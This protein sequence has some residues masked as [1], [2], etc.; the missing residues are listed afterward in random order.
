MRLLRAVGNSVLWLAQ[1]NPA[2][3]DNLRREAEKSKVAPERVIFAPRLPEMADHLARLRLADLFLDTLPYNGHVTASDALWAGLP[4]LT[5]L[6]ATF[7]GRVAASQLN[8]VGLPE[9]VTDS[10]ASYERLA[11]KLASDEPML[12]ALK[13]RLAAA[14]QSAPLFDAKRF[15]RHVEAAYESMSKGDRRG[16]RPRSFVV[17]QLP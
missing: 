2:A 17:D 11:L 6:G 12:R 10:L 14:R 5:C 13:E 4:V 9:L 1:S 7:A 16:A 8:A 15:A 3:M